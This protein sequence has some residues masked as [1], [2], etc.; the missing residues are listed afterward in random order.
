MEQILQ[1]YA[2]HRHKYDNK[3]L[4]IY[5]KSISLAFILN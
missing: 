5:Q 4:K 3:N 2:V 1:Y